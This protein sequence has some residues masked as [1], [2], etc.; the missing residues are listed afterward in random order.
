[1]NFLEGTRVMGALTIA[2]MVTMIALGIK[3]NDIWIITIG[4]IGLAINVLAITH[5]KH[6]EEP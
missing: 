1:M 6:D 3:Q 5:H 2:A 4:N